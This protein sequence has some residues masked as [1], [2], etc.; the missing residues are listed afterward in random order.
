MKETTVNFTGSLKFSYDENSPEFKQAYQDYKE[1]IDSGSTST[2]DMIQH[3][4]YNVG[5][6]GVENMVE[7]V[8][9]VKYNG[10]VED[11][12]MYCG[13]ELLDEGYD[14]MFGNVDLECDIE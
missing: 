7:G 8:G 14:N 10:K 9:Y 12:D 5:R 6:M 3:I 4:A 13:V 1:V 11:E 2:D